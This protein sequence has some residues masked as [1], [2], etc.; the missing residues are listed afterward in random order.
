ML[1]PRLL[2]LGLT[3]LIAGAVLFT[4]PVAAHEPYLALNQIAHASDAVMIGTVRSI[5]VYE[6][7][8]TRM[9][10][11]DVTFSDLDVVHIGDRSQDVGDEITLT[12]VGGMLADG[13]GV[14]VCD[15]PHFAEGER[16]MFFALNDGKG[17]VNPF[18]G[19]PQ[20]MFRIVTDESTG[21]P[22]PV[23]AGR[24]A[25]VDVQDGAIQSTP[26]VL[27]IRDG[28]AQCKSP[29]RAAPVTPR[30]M[31]GA[32]SAATRHIETAHL[33]LTLGEFRR[34]VEMLLA[35]PGPV[36]T[37]LRDR[38]AE[39]AFSKWSKRAQKSVQTVDDHAPAEHH[40]RGTLCACGYHD[41]YAVFEQVDN[42]WWSFP[43]N[44]QGMFMW[45]EYIDIFRYVNNDGSWGDNGDNEFGGFPSNSDL[46]DTWESSWGTAIAKTFVRFDS[47]CG[48]F[49]EADIVFNPAYTFVTDLSQSLED[50]NLV[51]YQ[52]VVMH[53]LG[54]AWGYITNLG[55]CN[56]DYS[57]STHSVMHAYYNFIV[58]NGRG[59]HAGDAQLV[60]ANYIPYGA[61]GVTDDLGVESYYVL[62]NGYDISRTDRDTD[63]GDTSPT[64]YHQGAPITLENVSLENMGISTLFNVRARVFFSSDQTI[65][66]SDYKAPGY[67]YWDQFIPEAWWTGDLTTT[68]PT[69]VPPG[70]YW[71]G[72]IVTEDGENYEVDG[73]PQNNKTFLTRKVRINPPP[74]VND[75]CEGAIEV[76]SGITTIDTSYS[77]TGGPAIPCAT[78]TNDVWFRYVPPCDGRLTIRTCDNATFDTVLALYRDNGNCNSPLIECNDD[79]FSCA[80]GGSRILETIVEDQP[81]L[82]RVGSNQEG[83][84]GTV[85][86]ELHLDGIVPN[87]F[88]SGAMLVGEG[89]YDVD[90]R[91]ASTDGNSE[92][93]AGGQVYNDLWYRIVA[94]CDGK[95]IASTCDESDFDTRIVIYLAAGA[96]PGAIKYGCSDDELGCGNGTSIAVGDISPGRHYW[97]RVGGATDLERGEAV[98]TLTCREDDCGDANGDGSVDFSDLEELLENWQQSVPIGQG[99]DVNYDGVVDFDDLNIL[100]DSWNDD[101]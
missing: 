80:N 70:D 97:I 92:S 75:E 62:N 46:Q 66:N 21:I 82:I 32:I 29:E 88:C 28:I 95:L 9:I 16:W 79:H 3:S 36:E 6:T 1:H 59:V 57:Y 20:G 49:D 50:S 30:A 77:Y 22:F 14:S 87:D 73:I 44:N 7:D 85:D 35:G 61:L 45:N 84:Y 58:E 33:P 17:Y 91:C 48:E 98:L 8:E 71:V 4:N 19:G 67:F 43:E 51:H 81:Y 83:Q 2:R 65:N 15:Q 52:Q 38:D 39:P 55:G 99:G 10:K 34:E 90:N 94:P 78:I 23:T 64:V 93:C 5:R 72:L 24:C 42:S 74:P 37:P 63:P 54:H 11:T 101:C 53:E 12:F 60:R 41:L 40:P 56:E 100:L 69:N 25:V 86:L 27:F 26:E 76:V 89:S 47:V 96:C 68:V 31:D 13:R 18:V